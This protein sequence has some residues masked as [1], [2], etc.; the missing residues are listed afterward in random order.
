MKSAATGGHDPWNVEKYLNIWI[1]NYTDDTL[2]YGTFPGMPANIQGLVCDFRAFGTTGTLTT[3]AA[4]GRTATHE[5]GHWL[6]LNHIWG[7]DGSA[8]TGSDNVADTPNQAGASPFGACR[9]FPAVTCMVATDD[10]PTAS[11][12]VT[13][14]PRRKGGGCAG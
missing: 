5:I 14:I 7:D 2:G 4:L 10:P 3:H 11:D 1:V 13:W 8:C 9:T 12:G 6:N